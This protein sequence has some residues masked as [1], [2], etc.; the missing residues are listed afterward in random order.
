MFKIHYENETTITDADPAMTLLEISLKNKIPHVHACGGHARCSTCRV[1]VTENLENCEPRNAAECE[2]AKNKGLAAKIRLACQTRVTGPVT[3]RRLVIDDEDLRDASETSNSGQEKQ[4][5]ILFSDIRSFTPFTEKNL[6]YDVVHV[7]NRYFRRMGD[8]VQRY[9]GY[10]DKYIGDGLMALFGL[11]EAGMDDLEITQE[12]REL[13]AR[14]VCRSAV[15][16]ALDMQKELVE[17]N[18]YLHH[19]L[20]HEFH[21]GVGVHF[22]DVIVGEMGHP[23]KRQFTA[24]GDNVNTAS[25]IESVTKQAAV[26]LLISQEVHSILGDDLTVHKRFRTK[27]KGKSGDYRLF[28]VTA[29]REPRAAEGQA[30]SPPQVLRPAQNIAVARTPV[31]GEPRVEL[32]RFDLP[33][34]EVRTVAD[35]TLAFLLD[36]AALPDFN[37]VPGQYVNVRIPGVSSVRTFSIASASRVRDFILIATRIRDSE[38]KQRMRELKPGDTLA[39]GAPEGVFALPADP[40]RPLVF[41]AGGIGI[42]PIRSMIEEMVETQVDRPI[43]LLYANRTPEASAFVPELTEWL[44]HMPNTRF[45]PVYS[46]VQA[47]GAEHG[48]LSGELIQKHVTEFETMLQSKSLAEEPLYYVVGPDAMTLDTVGMLERIGVPSDRIVLEAFY[49]YH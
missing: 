39:V 47:E 36:T 30:A 12:Q 23:D 37:F 3:I 14:N 33:I 35:Q 15:L 1:A 43:L 7:M 38:Y 2:L 22:G 16:A 44:N 21:I 42:T 29:V 18:R 20:D 19:H 26:P 49:G 6:P 27:L 32:Q 45:V 34:L 4:L 28:S 24:L 48:R 25:R 5:A 31:A 10:I 46:R 9:N 17:V 13:N 40:G 41:I 11:N 8:S